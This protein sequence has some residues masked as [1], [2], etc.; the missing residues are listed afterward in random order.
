MR[1]SLRTQ[2]LCGCRAGEDCTSLSAF[3]EDIGMLT[4]VECVAHEDCPLHSAC[5]K[6]KCTNDDLPPRVTGS[7]PSSADV[8]PLT[9]FDLLFNEDILFGRPGSTLHIK[10]KPRNP[11]GE[12]SRG[13]RGGA[14]PEKG[15]EER[16]EIVLPEDAHQK[17]SISHSSLGGSRA[18][19]LRPFAFPEAAQQTASLNRTSEGSAAPSWQIERHGQR[20]RITP[21]ANLAALPEGLYTVWMDFGFVTDLAGNSLEETSDAPVT[22]V[23]ARDADCPRLYV[24]G[25]STDNGNV[26]GAYV[27]IDPVNR[28]A[29]WRGGEGNLFFVYWREAALAKAPTAAGGGAAGSGASGQNA[30]LLQQQPGNWIVDVDLDEEEFLAFADLGALSASAEEGLFPSLVGSASAM[31]GKGAGSTPPSGKWHKWS[32]T[33]REPQPFVQ[34]F[35]SHE[36]DLTPPLLLAVEPPSFGEVS[37]SSSS[38]PEEPHSLRLDPQGIP[39]EPI[40][41]VFDKPVNF[42]HWASVRLLKRSDGDDEEEAEEQEGREEHESSEEESETLEGASAGER[43]RIAMEWVVDQE[44]GMR[45]EGK[46]IEVGRRPKPPGKV[47]D[48]ASPEYGLASLFVTKPLSPNAH[49]DLIADLGSFTDLSYNPWGPLRKATVSLVAAPPFCAASQGLGPLSQ[50]A[51]DSLRQEGWTEEEADAAADSGSYLLSP[52][53]EFTGKTSELPEGALASARCRSGF[54]AVSPSLPRQKEKPQTEP[55]RDAGTLRCSGGLWTGRLLPCLPLCGKHPLADSPSYL[56]KNALDGGSPSS[57]GLP[58]EELVVECAV[59]VAEENAEGQEEEGL[60]TSAPPPSAR[61]KCVAGKWTATSLKCNKDCAPLQRLLGPNYRVFKKKENTSE[62]SEEEA[63]EMVPSNSDELRKVFSEPEEEGRSS[64]FAV[65]GEERLISCREPALAVKLSGAEEEEGKEDA[66]ELVKCSEEGWTPRLSLQCRR[67][68]EQ[69]P[70]TPEGADVEGESLQHGAE[71]KAVCKP[72]YVP[73]GKASPVLVCDD[74][75][76]RRG[77]EEGPS[78]SRGFACTRACAPPQLSRAAYRVTFLNGLSSEGEEEETFDAAEA[79]DGFSGNVVKI[80]CLPGAKRA[81]DSPESE[82]LRCEDGSWGLQTVRCSA[83]CQSPLSQLGSHYAVV[84][85]TPALA[86]PETTPESPSLGP[87]FS[88]GAEA[89]V[90]CAEGSAVVSGDAEAVPFPLVCVNGVWVAKN[91]QSATREEARKGEHEEIEGDH[92]ISLRCAR[93][94]RVPELPVHLTLAVARPHAYAAKWKDGESLSLR[95]SDAFSSRDLSAAEQQGVG[96]STLVCRDGEWQ[97]SFP[98]GCARPCGGDGDEEEFPSK[99][100]PAVPWEALKIPCGGVCPEEAEASSP[101]IKCGS[102][103]NGIKDPLEEGV[104]CG[105]PFCSPCRNCSPLPLKPFLLQPQLFEVRPLSPADAS[106][107]RGSFTPRDAT[108]DPLTS[109]LV[110]T[111][112][113]PFL[114]QQTLHNSVV[115]VTCKGGSR[116]RGEGS[117]SS[118]SDERDRDR[119]RESSARES[120][121]GRLTL[122]GLPLRLR[123]A[124]GLW[125][126]FPDVAP[127]ESGGEDFVSTEWMRPPSWTQRNSS[128]SSKGSSPSAVLPAGPLTQTQDEALRASLLTNCVPR[129]WKTDFGG[130]GASLGLGGGGKTE[131]KSSS[132]TTESLLSGLGHSSSQALRSA[133]L[134]A[135]A[136]PPLRW[137]GEE[138]LAWGAPLLRGAKEDKAFPARRRECLEQLGLSLGGVLAGEC[139]ALAFGASDFKTASFCRGGCSSS[140][141]AAARE[142]RRCLD[143]AEPTKELGA[144]SDKTLPGLVEELDAVFC[145]RQEGAF[146]FAKARDTFAFLERLHDS[147]SIAEEFHR[148]V[149]SNREADAGGALSPRCFRSNARYPLLLQRLGEVFDLQLP[150]QSVVQLDAEASLLSLTGAGLGGEKL[151]E[152]GLLGA[153]TRG[154]IQDLRR[155]PD[156]LEVLCLEV[157]GVSCTAQVLKVA[158]SNPLERFQSL[159]A[160]AASSSLSLGGSGEGAEG[161]LADSEVCSS[162]GA[163]TACHLEAMRRLGQLLLQPAKRRFLTTSEDAAWEKEN[164]AADG[165]DAEK[166]APSGIHPYDLAL[167]LA[168]RVYGRTFCQ[169]SASNATCGSRVFPVSLGSQADL[170]YKPAT[171]VELPL[172]ECPLAFVGDGECDASCNTAACDFDRGDCSV[173]RM[174]PG[175]V[176]HLQTQ[177]LSPSDACFPFRADFACSSAKCRGVFRGKDFV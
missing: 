32:G 167:G 77:A 60:S 114:P 177:T 89:S 147:A 36:V 11:R 61:V 41:L 50:A 83:P 140:L 22:F 37:P 47:V 14:D 106:T 29:A 97:G 38:A 75:R 113:S 123:C 17:R 59:P 131:G 30:S 40:R 117:L 51:A 21:E 133:D 155:L 52:T 120:Q 91:P 73:A 163:A 65:E 63:V 119:D 72:G 98:S 58:G 153:G 128:N 100:R 94:C 2:R 93:F 156:I 6:A 3:G 62:R 126:A 109:S 34:F 31:F 127:G 56:L 122:G 166:E 66:V 111:A 1:Y 176:S 24:T 53:G 107:A 18:P 35:C 129:L 82:T 112:G 118:T 57:K 96:T 67:N 110:A 152:E 80:E 132:R 10:C 42:G 141:K 138:F 137:R 46:G 124:D 102:C 49:Y 104:D 151:L 74:G 9:S 55:S 43:H 173:R 149:C 144:A 130:G 5:V 8:G 39:V 26:N 45:G 70:E 143:D 87:V 81:P 25:F 158:A 115:Q 84:S 7:V 172:C 116:V 164:E 13:R 68:C 69:P 19:R 105:G 170:A 150:R 86:F 169:R 12:K 64:G 136:S 121:R 16:W 71:W 48:G 171:R 134:A 125:T 160:S 168:M 92:G 27:A 165:R 101:S 154:F 79:G 157:E 88:H 145:Q 44:A 33:Q 85:S 139:G 108:L 159:S 99:A 95:C 20:L 162:G 23:I 54:S 76:W 78:L 28:H 135:A 4:T 142:A 103:F 175:L 174:M 15:E 161:S 146:C 90:R 148:R